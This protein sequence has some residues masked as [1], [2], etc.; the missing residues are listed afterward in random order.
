[1]QRA[2]SHAWSVGRSVGWLWLVGC[3]WL[4]CGVATGLGK[5]LVH[6][7]KYSDRRPH[8]ENGQVET[9][10]VRMHMFLTFFFNFHG[11]MFAPNPKFQ[12]SLAPTRALL[13]AATA[14]A[15]D[16]EVKVGNAC[17]G[18]GTGKMVGVLTCEMVGRLFWQSTEFGRETG[19][20]VVT[21][22]GVQ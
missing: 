19:L 22:L 18:G 5:V 1:M 11:L 9:K 12:T 10:A 20:A 4:W 6:S 13:V 16:E 21:I 3:G 15:L 2:A 17:K 8:R 7:P 14:S